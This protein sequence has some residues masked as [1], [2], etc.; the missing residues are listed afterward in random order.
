MISIRFATQSGGVAEGVSK[1]VSK[2]S[3]RR[4]NAGFDTSLRS[5]STG[6][7]PKIKQPW[8]CKIYVENAEILCYTM[9]FILHR[10]DSDL[11]TLFD[12]NPAVN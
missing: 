3:E 5:Y 8:N 12:Q 9:L 2:P 11:L 7:H 1:P 6:V 10:S 4:M